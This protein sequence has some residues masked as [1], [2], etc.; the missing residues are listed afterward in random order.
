MMG[1]HSDGQDDLYGN[2]SQ[3]STLM[4]REVGALS[5]LAA[6]VLLTAMESRDV[7]TKATDAT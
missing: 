5:W 1:G 3:D 7:V 2:S 6:G 4:M